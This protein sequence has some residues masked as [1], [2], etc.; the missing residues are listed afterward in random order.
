MW[1]IDKKISKIS[2]IATIT[3]F[4]TP[5]SSTRNLDIIPSDDPGEVLSVSSKECKDI[6][7]PSHP[8]TTMDK[9]HRQTDSQTDNSIIR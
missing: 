6:R 7:D 4:S 3:N 1:S 9:R 8:V 2:D 5:P